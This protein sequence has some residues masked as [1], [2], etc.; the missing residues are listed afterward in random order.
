ML[1]KL[2]NILKVT[3][4]KIKAVFS[5]KNLTLSLLSA[6]LV[7]GAGYLSGIVTHVIQTKLITNPTMYSVYFLVNI[8]IFII[9]IIGPAF[10]NAVYTKDWYSFLY[11]IILEILW[12]SIFLAILYFTTQAKNFEDIITQ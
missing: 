8:L 12:L 2:Q 9:A 1:K 6:L 4:E 7:I 10:L 3:G 11:I 5:L